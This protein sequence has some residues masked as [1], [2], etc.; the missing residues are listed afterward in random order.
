MRGIRHVSHSDSNDVAVDLNDIDEVERWK[1]QKA[2]E[3]CRRQL[4]MN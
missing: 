2:I 1:G 4:V 3:R